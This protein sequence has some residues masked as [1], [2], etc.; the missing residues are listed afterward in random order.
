MA[1]IKNISGIDTHQH[2]W[3]YDAVRDSWITDEMRVI[4]KDFLPADLKIQLDENGFEGCVAVQSDQTE[5]H[6]D[7]LLELANDNSFIKGVV[8]W[9]DLQADNIGE[10]LQYYHQFEII[11][12]F[13]HV[14]QGESNRALMLTPAF[15]RGIAALQAFNYTYD[16]L[17][18]PDQLQYIPAFVAAFPNQKFVIDHIAKPDIKNNKIADWKKDIQAV[19]NYANVSCKISGMV[20]EADFTNWKKADFT[21]YIDVVVEA[22]GVDRVMF[23]SDW[24]VCLVAGDYTQ[25]LGIVKEYFA[26][27]SPEDQIKIFR[28]SAIDFY[29]LAC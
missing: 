20:T 17:I 18:F 15:M 22:F 9:V 12:G 16:I 8:G 6:N 5:G 14:L 11:K 24:P 7:F 21:P 1:E 25:V 23:G 3:K 27:F 28:T 13:R 26:S 2:F 10:R 29:D 19:A 4:K